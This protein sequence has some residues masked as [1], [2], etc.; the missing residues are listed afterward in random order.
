MIDDVPRTSDTD[1]AAASPTDAAPADVCGTA[2]PELV[3]LILELTSA[4]AAIDYANAAGV[5]KELEHGLLEAQHAF[6]SLPEG[7]A[8]AEALRRLDGLR[9]IADR[10]LAIAPVPSA[11]AIAA[12]KA[13]DSS[14]WFR[15][16]DEWAAT[17]L[18]HG[19]SR[20]RQP[21]R[22]RSDTRPESPG[23]L[24]V[25]LIDPDHT[26]TQAP[27]APVAPEGSAPDEKHR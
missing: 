26:T 6:E 24:R 21:R 22:S 2:I 20:P 10:Q 27:L 7:P 25:E 1:P 18:G 3:Q 5:R 11:A 16:A 12:A 14:A 13:G 23:A 15:E 8:R 9:T 19:S 17:R 4:N